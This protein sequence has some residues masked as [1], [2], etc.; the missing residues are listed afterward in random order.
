MHNSPIPDNWLWHEDPKDAAPTV[1]F[2]IDGVLSDANNRQHFL[3]ASPRNWRAFFDACGDDPLIEETAALLQLLDPSLIIV[4]L[5]GRPMRVRD[6]TVKWLDAFGVRWDL[7]VMREAGDYTS[8]SEFKRFS[9]GQLRQLGYELKLAVDDHS[10]NVAM[11]REEGLPTVYLHS[12]YYETD[13]PSGTDAGK[14]DG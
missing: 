13:L 6:K 12:G 10:G 1:V 7:L 5:T 4:L 9:V 8:A 14:T 2:D 11:F 3:E